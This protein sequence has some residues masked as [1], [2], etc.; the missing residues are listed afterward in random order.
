MTLIYWCI[1]PHLQDFIIIIIIII[2]CFLPVAKKD[3]LANFNASWLRQ[4]YQ[5]ASPGE[6]RG[7]NRV[8]IKNY[9]NGHSSLFYSTVQG[10]PGGPQTTQKNGQKVFKSQAVNIAM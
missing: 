4:R 8:L 7:R 3:A 2:S 5:M 1:N 9:V 6:T 10:L